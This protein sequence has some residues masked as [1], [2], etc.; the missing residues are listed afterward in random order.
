MLLQFPTVWWDNSLP[1]WVSANRGART[2]EAS[3]EFSE[4]QNLNHKSMIPGSHTLLSFLGDPQSSRYEPMGDA[5]VQ[6][7]VMARLRAQNPSVAIPEPVAFFLSRHGTDPLS[8]GAYSGFEV[9]FKDKARWPPCAAAHPP[10]PLAPAGW[11]GG[12]QEAA[13]KRCH[14]CMPSES[15][16]LSP[17]ACAVHHYSEGA[18]QGT[19]VRHGSRSLCGGGY[20]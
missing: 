16:S 15:L 7:A 14:L 6:A 17:S 20:V 11:V 12:V 3:G 10:V 8:F 1:R 13:P 9:G 4:W 2:L 5:D 19:A 18:P